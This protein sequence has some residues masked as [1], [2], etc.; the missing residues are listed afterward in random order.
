MKR[1]I[2]VIFLFFAFCFFLCIGAAGAED[3]FQRGVALYQQGKFADAE[4]AFKECAQPSSTVFYNLGNTCY[5]RG[6]LGE[7][8]FYWERGIKL[9]PLDQD[10]AGNLE[11]ASKLLHDAVPP[12]QT[13]L[14]L[15]WLIALV[16]GI[17]IPYLKTAAS[18]LWILTNIAFLGMIVSNGSFRWLKALAIGL[19]SCCLL[20]TVVLGINIYQ[21]ESSHYGILLVPKE[22]VRSG[23]GTQNTVLMEI[24]EGLRIKILNTQADWI[25]IKIAGGYSGWV[26]AQSIGV[27]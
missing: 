23:P 9:D 24:H 22:S 20:T 1:A 19:L 8:I 5:K 21:F 18:W 25:A 13:P 7:A 6:R 10:C 4:A 15:Q 2:A 27:I 3:A 12:D 16:F 17:P 11:L 26:P 14:P